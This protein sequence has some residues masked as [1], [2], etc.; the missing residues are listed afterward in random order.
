[1]LTIPFELKLSKKRLIAS[2][3][4]AV[5]LEKVP[6]SELVAV[7]LDSATYK[8][9]LAATKQDSLSQTLRL[10]VREYLQKTEEP[11]VA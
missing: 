4:M 7:R 5:Q 10:A 8:Q 3:Q 11:L 2:L 6:L 1:M 9:L